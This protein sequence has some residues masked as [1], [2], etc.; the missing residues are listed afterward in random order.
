MPLRT[1]LLSGNPR[2]YALQVQLKW[3]TDLY[4]FTRSFVM[5]FLWMLPVL[6]LPAVPTP[7]AQGVAEGL[8]DARPYYLRDLYLQ[9]D[10]IPGKNS[11]IFQKLHRGDRKDLLK[12]DGSGS[13]R[14]IWS[15]WCRSFEKNTGTEPAKVFLRVYVDG[16]KSAGLEGKLDEIFLAAERTGARHMPQPAFNYEGAYNLYLPIF[17]RAGIRIEMEALDDLDEFYVQVDYR[18]TPAQESPAR[19]SAAREPA[20]L[21]LVYKG[22]GAP[23]F[24]RGLTNQKTKVNHTNFTFQLIPGQS[25]PPLEIGGPGIIRQ[26]SFSGE[27]LDQIQL[28]MFWDGQK[29]PAVQAPLKY[30]FGRFRTIGLFSRSD[31]ADCYLPMPF[32]RDARIA[33]SLLPGPS[34]S[35]AV[36]VRL[37]WDEVRELPPGALYFCARYR[38]EKSTTGFQ[39]YIIM[40]A[41]GPGLFV[42]LNLFDSGHNHG[43]GDAA[44]IDA[45]GPDP[46]VLH[47]ICAEDYFSFAWHKTGASHDYA[48]APE[49]ESRYRFHFENPYPFKRSLQV[50]FGTFGD[51]NPKS[52][53]FWYQ[54]PALEDANTDSWI[55]PD[56][57]WKVLGPLAMAQSFPAENG[58]DK[59]PTTVPLNS[60][61]SIDISW[62]P[63]L[64]YSGFLDLCHHYRYF[65]TRTS[66]T[67]FIAGDGQYRA[68]TEL[69]VP[70]AASMKWRVGHDDRFALRI[71]GQPQQVFNE[72]AGFQSSIVSVNLNEGWNTVEAT[73]ENHENVD[74]RWPGFSLSLNVQP[75]DYA[76]MRWGK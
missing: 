35:A 8:E 67:G 16:E 38:E 9:R 6:F 64:M 71:N 74:W 68:V 55:A 50:R 15:T 54:G 25:S 63:A 59:M 29:S 1:G 19:L 52:V 69:Y 30:F 45:A 40:R 13:V 22:K 12:L 66:G 10:Y 46:Q 58:P 65:T 5:R 36:D 24:D 37:T 70:S 49:H 18:K 47:G 31:S 76:K 27:A 14:H 3:D 53:A 34:R 72:S 43:G 33:L 48:G 41:A 42:G 2:G 57:P 28:Q 62:Q 20:G 51:L 7:F 39:D 17:F 11:Y 60:P 4:R 21:R 26:L 44:L 32:N 73:F 75:Q 56:A 61:V 23:E